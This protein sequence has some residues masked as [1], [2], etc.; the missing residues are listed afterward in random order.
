M[1][2]SRSSRDLRVQ[3]GRELNDLCT[4]QIAPITAFLTA[5]AHTHT[6]RAIR[7]GKGLKISNHQTIKTLRGPRK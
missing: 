6:H 3:I 5:S 2:T 1:C 4:Q 7:H